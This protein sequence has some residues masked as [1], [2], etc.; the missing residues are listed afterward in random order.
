MQSGAVEIVTFE[1]KQESGKFPQFFWKKSGKVVIKNRKSRG[2]AL[3]S[4]IIFTM[5]PRSL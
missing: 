4:L 5:T 3:S 1:E 2:T